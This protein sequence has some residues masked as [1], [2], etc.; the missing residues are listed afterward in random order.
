M[1][2]KLFDNIMDNTQNLNKINYVEEEFELI[3]KKQEI[4]QKQLEKTFIYQEKICKLLTEI[5]NI[6][7]FNKD[8]EN[9][10]NK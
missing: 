7:Y 9:E 2:T 8:I 10:K 1:E 4:I 3:Q 5:Q 6:N